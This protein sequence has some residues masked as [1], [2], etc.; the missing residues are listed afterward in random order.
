VLFLSLIALVGWGKIK[1]NDAL[2]IVAPVTAVVGT[3]L[4]FYFGGEKNNH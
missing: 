3:A 1:V 4:G 2:S